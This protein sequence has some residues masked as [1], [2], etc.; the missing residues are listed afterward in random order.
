MLDYLLDW[1][2]DKGLLTDCAPQELLH[3]STHS[4]TIPLHPANIACI[5][6]NEHIF[7]Y[8]TTSD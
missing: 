5:R 8:H 7:F 4:G 6:Y 3:I 1:L 2:A